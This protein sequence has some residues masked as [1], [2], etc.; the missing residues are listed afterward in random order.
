[1]TASMAAAKPV[2]NTT[3][4]RQI[5]EVIPQDE[6]PNAAN[7]APYEAPAAAPQQAQQAVQDA[8]EGSTGTRKSDRAT[9]HKE[10]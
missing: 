9:K 6:R 2:A 7:D 1:M 8:P 10:A 4:K 5:S 3:H